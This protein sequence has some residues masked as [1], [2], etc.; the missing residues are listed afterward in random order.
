VFSLQ[1][2]YLVE[3]TK[4]LENKIHPVSYEFLLEVKRLEA[5]RV[6]KDDIK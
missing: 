3:V 4:G 2:L 6:W 1:I 5:L